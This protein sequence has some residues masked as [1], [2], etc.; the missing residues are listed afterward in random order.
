MHLE[1]YISI[2]KN[3]I[4]DMGFYHLQELLS[5]LTSKSIDIQE[6]VVRS[7]IHIIYFNYNARSNTTQLTKVLRS[8]IKVKNYRDCLVDIELS[9]SKEKRK[10]SIIFNYKYDVKEP[11]IIKVE[12]HLIK[13]TSYRS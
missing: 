5:S 12:K 10:K 13:H 2:D 1:G 11:E 3:K 7:D 6:N 9:L 4:D 8:I